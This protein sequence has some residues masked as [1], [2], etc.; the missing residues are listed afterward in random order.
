MFSSSGILN[1]GGHSSGP[2][3]A[4]SSASSL[5]P[6]SPQ[7][8]PNHL[9]SPPHCA[10]TS[11]V[12]TKDT[13]LSGGTNDCSGAATLPSGLEATVCISTGTPLSPSTTTAQ[14]LTNHVQL[15]VPD[16]S[17]SLSLTGSPSPSMLSSDNPKL[18]ALPKGKANTTSNDDNNNY[19]N[20][21]GTPE[22]IINVHLGL[23]SAAKPMSDESVASSPLLATATSCPQSTDPRITNSLSCLNSPSITNSQGHTV[24]GKGLEDLQSP[25]KA[26]PS[27]K[28]Q[29]HP[30]PAS[31]TPWSSFSIYPSSNEVLKVCR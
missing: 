24:N 12:H 31:L 14:G 9:S 2:C 4:S 26:E 15:R 29:R 21:G 27:V 7:T 1:Q 10:T 11:G 16:S 3:T 17:A 8:T 19:S 6:T 25:L 20:N 23:H 28:P 5:S 22:K 30:V 18:S 13:M